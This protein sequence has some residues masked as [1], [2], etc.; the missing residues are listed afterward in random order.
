M[1]DMLNEVER[2]PLTP[3]GEDRER[4][5]LALTAALQSTPAGHGADSLL[6]RAAR[7][8]EFLGGVA[9]VDPLM[10]SAR[11]QLFRYAEQGAEAG[12]SFPPP[13]GG[14]TDPI[15]DEAYDACSGWRL[16]PTV[17]QIM[18][19]VNVGDAQRQG[20]LSAMEEAATDWDDTC[21]RVAERPG[22]ERM[23]FVYEAMIGAVAAYSLGKRS[24]QEADPTWRDF[25][26]PPISQREID[27]EVAGFRRALERGMV[28]RG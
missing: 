17:A 25:V 7:F 5:R 26:T 28:P 3:H 10:K 22:G 9:A 1:S 27:L 4:R 15:P 8:L 13:S 18:V 14:P 23:V 19:P 11:D 2:G 20:L 6:D 21:A 16:P 12:C 24:G